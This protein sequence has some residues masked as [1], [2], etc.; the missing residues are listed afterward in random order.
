MVASKA[1]ARRSWPGSAVDGAGGMGNGRR[2]DAAMGGD[3]GCWV[4]Q[5]PILVWAKI[6]P[7]DT[8]HKIWLKTRI[9]LA[10]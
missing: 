8:D 5:A 3:F 4:V 10:G 2:E 1:G 6:F 7:R 9:S